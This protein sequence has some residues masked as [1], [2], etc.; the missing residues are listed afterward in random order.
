MRAIVLHEFGP[1]DRLRYEVV[2]D[3]VPR[4]G[5]VRIRVHAGTVNRVL[6]VAVRAGKQPQRKVQ[7][8]HIGGV[9]P[10]GVTHG[11]G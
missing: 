10:V 8:P 6:D 3:P 9:D 7:L 1:P 4:Q 11:H 2:P 5:E